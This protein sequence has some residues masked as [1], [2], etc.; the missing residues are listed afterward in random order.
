MEFLY[1]LTGLAIGAVTV[2]LVLRS[3]RAADASLRDAFAALSAD[4][5]RANNDQFLQLAKTKLGEIQSQATGEL[6]T[7]QQAISA[8]VQPIADT[9]KRFDAQIQD[10]ERQRV[11]AH[12]RLDEQLRSLQSETTNLVKALRSPNVRGQW[13]ELQLRRVVEAAGMV[14]HCDFSF[15]ESIHGDEGRLTPDL[16]VR[17]PGGRNVVVDAKVPAT[18][19]LA[20]QDATDEPVRQA[21]LRDHSRQLRE[22]VTRLGNKSYWTHFQPAPDI[23]VLFVPAEALLTS[24]LQHDPGLLEFSLGRNVLLASPV[25]L[26]GLL[27]AVAYGWQQEKMAQN[28]LEISELGRTL[29]ERICKLADHFEKLGSSLKRSVESYNEAVGSMESR[30]LVSARRLKDLGVASGDEPLALPPIDTS[31]RPTRA[32]ELTGLFDNALDGELLSEIE[33]GKGEPHRPT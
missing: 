2:G 24:A 31:V 6:A 10:V 1:L 5:L 12:A 13:G 19:Y 3:S 17:L 4:A 29:Y 22:H 33:E 21:R 9:L 16:I 30:V 18:A 32:P 25:T 11:G 14:E 26:V 23:V 28:A 15:K 7:R 8:M 27:R 20:A